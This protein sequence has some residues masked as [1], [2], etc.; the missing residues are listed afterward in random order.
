M[1]GSGVGRAAAVVLCDHAE[2]GVRPGL[3]RGGEPVDTGGRFTGRPL[4]RQ[5]QAGSGHRAPLLS[6]GRPVRGQ[7]CVLSAL[8]WAVEGRGPPALGRGRE[9]QSGPA[10]H[11][12]GVSVARSSLT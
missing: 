7:D 1:S 8:G 3:W 12:A 6:P 10:E 11:G 4:G 5:D 9:G 2:A